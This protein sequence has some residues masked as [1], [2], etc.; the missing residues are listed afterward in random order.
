MQCFAMF[1]NSFFFTP[2]FV[3]HLRRAQLLDSSSVSQCS[4]QREENYSEPRRGFASLFFGPDGY[5]TMASLA[6]WPVRAGILTSSSLCLAFQPAAT[7]RPSMLTERGLACTLW[8][9][10]VKPRAVAG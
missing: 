10:T 1:V 8:T 4:L 5:S 9:F 7:A 6:S 2:P 3:A